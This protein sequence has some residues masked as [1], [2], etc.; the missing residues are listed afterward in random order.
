MTEKTVR[1]GVLGL[2]TV[3]AGTIKLLQD[4]AD[5]IAAKTGA[6]FE[7]VAA[8]A[9]DITKSRDCDL[10]GVALTTDP[11][12]VVNADVDVVV[13]L[14]GGYD[15]ARELALAA[16]KQGKHFVTANKA[17]IAK[18]GNELF[19]EA[20]KTKALVAYEA[21][22]AGGIP[23]IK[24]LRE[25]LA[26]NEISQ[27][28]GIINGTTNFILTEMRDKGRDFADV[29]AEAQALGYA[30]ADPTF[31]VGG[32]D[33]A[34]KLVILTSLAFG[35]PLNFDGAYI[36]GIEEI[37]T[38]DVNLAGELGFKLKHLGIARQT[39]A[40]VEMR[41]HPALVPEAHLLAKVDGVM[42][43]VLVNGNFVG[44]TLYYGPGAGAGPTASAV[45]ADI[46]DVARQLGCNTEN[47]IPNSGYAS[48]LA[49]PAP[50]LTADAFNCEYYLKLSVQD[51]SGALAQVTSALADASVSID[52]VVQHEPKGDSACATLALITHEVNEA[53]LNTA[54]Q[55]LEGLDIVAGNVT[56]MRVAR[57]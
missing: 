31:D 2:G 55:A 52:A 27:L 23:V 28:A 11:F 46:L 30:E 17:L 19:A 7:V 18:H 43:A 21:S 1:L 53:Q 16:I 32:I 26:G 5:S 41:V 25:G 40:G 24:A 12:V 54:I 20:E 49:N 38:E 35:I 51:E 56:R 3:G 36:E 9:R 57:F 14:I 33:A 10:T 8:S 42:N 15:L 4:N 44:E 6:R 47:T 45:V 48:G 34:H 29:L 37:T 39:E 22:V 13:E 50:V